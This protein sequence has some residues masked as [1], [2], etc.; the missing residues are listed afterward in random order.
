MFWCSIDPA[1][2]CGYAY[3]ND[4]ELVHHACIKARGKKG[5][6]Y[7]GTDIVPSR[8]DAWVKAL[9]QCKYCICELGMGNFRGS[10]RH[11]GMQIGYL[12]ARCEDVGIEVQLLNVSEWRR[13]IKE[14]FGVSWPNNRDRAKKLAQQLVF[15]HYKLDVTEDEADAILIGR[16]AQ[17]LGLVGI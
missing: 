2:C 3:W 12:E 13:V 1:K 5:A 6:W 9:N 14:E 11:M 17:R 10:D 7:F 8:K 16:A 15:K 4:T